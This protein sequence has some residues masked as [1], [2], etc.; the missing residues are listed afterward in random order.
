MI[1]SLSGGSAVADPGK[2][3]GNSN[4]KQTATDAGCSEVPEVHYLAPEQLDE[5]VRLVEQGRQL[6]ADVD[7]GHVELV[8]CTLTLQRGH[9]GHVG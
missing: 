5:A 6:D 4:G 1:I 7:Q 8:D 2:S 9:G 3:N